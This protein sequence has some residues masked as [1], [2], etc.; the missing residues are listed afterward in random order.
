MYAGDRGCCEL[1]CCLGYFCG[2]LASC[3]RAK[4]RAQI[5]ELVRKVQEVAGE[6]AEVAFVDQ[7]YTGE[8]AA[9]AAK[10]HGIQLQVVTHSEAR[11]GFVLLPRRWVVKRS[12]GWMN[13]S[14]R[15]AQDYERLPQTLAD[16]RF[17]AFAMP[18]LG[19]W[20]SVGT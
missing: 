11:S 17:V 6:Q 12:F 18:M 8:A 13:R 15:L 10:A 9:E 19:K 2:F 1:R 4:D 7:G 5:A 16:L 3:A 14:R 20:F